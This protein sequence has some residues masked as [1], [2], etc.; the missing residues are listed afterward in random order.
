VVEI[1]WVN[2]ILNVILCDHGILKNRLAVGWISLLA[3]QQNSWTSAIFG[4]IPGG[5]MFQLQ[6]GSQ[7]PWVPVLSPFQQAKFI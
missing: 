5:D 2:G 7:L 6:I 1:F 3:E 4:C